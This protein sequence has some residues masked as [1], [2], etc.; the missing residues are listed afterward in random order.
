[1]IRNIVMVKLKAGVRPETLDAFTDA[2]LRL[3]VPGMTGLTTYRD[4]G[5]RDG[6]C[7][8]VVICDLENEEA[9]S[10]YDSDSEHN[11][12]RR[13]LAAPIAERLERIQVRL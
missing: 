12:I 3:Q 9:Y 6:N 4:A 10:R 7:D 2:M 13:E 1:M 11:R 8:V 5:L